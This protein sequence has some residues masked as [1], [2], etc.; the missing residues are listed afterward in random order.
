MDEALHLTLIFPTGDDPARLALLQLQTPLLYPR[1]RLGDGENLGVGVYLLRPLRHGGPLE[2]EPA[3]L[4]AEVDGG[5]L[6]LLGPLLPGGGAP[7]GAVRRHLPR[8][9]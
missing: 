1:P 7:A 8:G 9:P 2:L 6:L 4:G 3:L 5:L